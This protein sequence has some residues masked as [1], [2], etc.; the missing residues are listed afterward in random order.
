[1]RYRKIK[2]VPWHGNSIRCK[3]LRQLFAKAM[4]AELSAGKRILNVDETWI[5]CTDFR[6]MKWKAKGDT[7]SVSHKTISYRVNMIA[8]LDTDG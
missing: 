5:P 8:A 7:N 4:L 3:V 1:M 2:P 6:R